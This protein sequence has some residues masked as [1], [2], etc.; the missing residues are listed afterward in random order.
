MLTHL[1]LLRSAMV[2]PL[3]DL[4][5]PFRARPRDFIPLASLSLATG[6]VDPRPLP[7]GY[8]AF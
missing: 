5:D 4:P 8:N 7:S 1:L 6:A 2:R 3:R